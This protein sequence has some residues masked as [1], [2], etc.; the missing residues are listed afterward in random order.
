MNKN[1]FIEELAKLDIYPT[2][3]QLE[4]LDNYYKI[5]VE[6]NKVM[7]L[8][9]ITD[10]EQVYLKHFYD[11]LTLQKIIDLKQDYTLCDI[12]SGAGFPGIVLKILFPNLKITL[13]D[14]LNKRIEFLNIVIKKLDLKDIET[15]CVRVEEYG[16]EQR[17]KYDLVTARAVAQLN[18][19]LEYAIPLTK[20]NGYFI[21]MKANLDEGYE[22]ALTKLDSQLVKK[23]E[24]KLPIENSNRTILLI[25]K[26]KKTNK[27]FPRNNS[28]IRKHPL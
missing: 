28:Q 9:G 6:Y 27:L 22:K 1:R 13:L 24:F 12:G 10:Y 2:S 4:Q 16:K 26:K 15:K 11:S 21:P 5:L 8:T 20:V 18:I 7:N 3:K 25:Q 19:L 23:I 17:E 14:S